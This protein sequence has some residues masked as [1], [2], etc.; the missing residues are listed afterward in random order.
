MT[1][2]IQKYRYMDLLARRKHCSTNTQARMLN[3]TLC[4]LRT[5][6]N[7][8]VKTTIFCRKHFND[9][10]PQIVINSN[11]KMLTEVFRNLS[12]QNLIVH[13]LISTFYFPISI[14]IIVICYVIGSAILF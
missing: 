7:G 13:N 12:Y 14:V 6:Y 3:R 11:L 5:S 10:F 1:Y 8:Q 2:S 9:Y 4:L